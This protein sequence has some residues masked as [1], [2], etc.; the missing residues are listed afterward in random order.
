MREISFEERF[1]VMG[2]DSYRLST[3]KKIEIATNLVDC[4]ISDKEVS[5][6]AARFI[7]IWCI[8][9][10]RYKKA[11]LDVWNMVLDNYTP[12][13]TPLLYRACDKL[14]RIREG[15]VASYCEN[16]ETS[17]KFKPEK[18]VVLDTNLALQGNGPHELFVFSFFPLCK[19]M[20]KHNVSCRYLGEEE[21]IVRETYYGAQVFNRV[22]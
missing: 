7:S 10:N 11:F 9:G 14:Q 19:L 16:F 13:G 21:Y 1:G 12:T 8:T 15:K 20:E 22:Y 3:A 18:I 5:D 4:M 2:T 6:D 17:L